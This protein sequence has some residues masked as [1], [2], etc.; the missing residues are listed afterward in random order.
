MKLKILRLLHIW[1]KE[2]TVK[3][4]FCEVPTASLILLGAINLQIG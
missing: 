2:Q 3:Y 1:I 4:S